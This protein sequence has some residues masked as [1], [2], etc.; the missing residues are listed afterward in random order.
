[1]RKIRIGKDIVIRWTIL[2][3]GESIS[4]EVRKVT[5]IC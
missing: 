3:D 2:T 5:K 4:L 1:M